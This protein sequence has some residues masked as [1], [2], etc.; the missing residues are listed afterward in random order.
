MARTSVGL[1]L[2]S[3]AV[4]LV[5]TIAVFGLIGWAVVT[6]PGWP[7]V[8]D[9]FLDGELLA[10]SFPGIATAFLV[11]VR[12]FLI[13]EV[14]TLVLGLLLAIMRSLGGPVFFPVRLLA[15]LYV[16]V[17]RAL[18]GILVIFSLG[19]GVPALGIAGIP[20][21]PFFWAVVTLTMVYSAY[22]SEVYRAGI[23]SVHPSQDAAARSLGLS[24]L[25]SLRHVVVPQA[26]RRVV[27]PLLNDFIGL[28]KDSVLVSYI[29]VVETFRQAQ[30]VKAAT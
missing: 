1:A 13:A 21:D 23:E 9:G 27:P 10:E 19:L 16:D 11:N 2:R 20:N 28:Q 8:R 30:I 7:Q 25:Q 17:F 24:R 15:T 29:G 14:L 22:V 26:I 3:T 5:S 4:A 12:L 6:S 18:P